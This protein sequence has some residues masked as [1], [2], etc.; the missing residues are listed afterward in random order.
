M[1]LFLSTGDPSALACFLSNAV[2][3]GRVLFRVWLAAAVVHY[4][5]FNDDTANN[6]WKVN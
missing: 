4:L 6:G 5:S 2:V 1:G 3:V